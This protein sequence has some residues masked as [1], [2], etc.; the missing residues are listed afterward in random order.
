[1]LP[2]LKSLDSRT[3][4]LDERVALGEH[5]GLLV[6]RLHKGQLLIKQKPLKTFK[7]TL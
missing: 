1:M 3:V 7:E 6:P 5:E 4:Q 2:Q